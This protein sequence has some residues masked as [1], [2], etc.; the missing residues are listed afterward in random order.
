MTLSYAKPAVRSAWGDTAGATNLQ[1]PGDTFVSTGWSQSTT[2][3]AR[4]Y[5]NWAL[6]WSSAAVRY[7]CQHGV[8]DYDAAELYP[9]EAIVRGPDGLLYRSLQAGNTGKTPASN[10]AW[11]G[12]PLV[13]SPPAASN[14]TSIAT[15][16]WVR[17]TF[18]LPGD[19]VFSSI[20]GQIAPSQVPAGAVTQFQ[21]NLAINWGQ[22]TGTKN[23]SQLNGLT[24]STSA[25]ANT[26]AQRDGSGD[27]AMVS[28]NLTSPAGE[29]PP[30]G[31][32]VITTEGTSGGT[33]L[34]RKASLSYVAT[35]IYNAVVASQISAL[36]TLITSVKNSIAAVQSSITPGQSLT[37]GG[38]WWEQRPS[39][40][41]EQWGTVSKQASGQNAGVSFPKSFISDVVVAISETGGSGVQPNGYWQRITAGSVNNSGFSISSDVVDGA[42]NPT[43]T[44]Y[45]HAI[46]RW[47]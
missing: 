33:A 9:A 36:N 11:W 16:S 18:V 31:Q 19:L 4:Q 15:T 8:V 43:I 10:T 22:L 25:S 40:V 3:P 42:Q 44:V 23:A 6:S 2:P 12:S 30:V 5:W 28:A 39:G 38:P 24:Q 41:M 26:I 37:G 21:G 13:P 17:A 20:G 7:L 29:N 1:D 32:F 46:G 35:Q 34:T 47:K 27:L 45:W 14:D